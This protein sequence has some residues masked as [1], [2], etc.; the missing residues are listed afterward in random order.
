MS[1]YTLNTVLR[2]S[3]LFFVGCRFV[4]Y[5]ICGGSEYGGLELEYVLRRGDRKT[6]YFGRESPV[7][8][9]ACCEYIS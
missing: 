5:V 9:P 2:F 4:F 7:G 3:A 6:N 8:W 1:V